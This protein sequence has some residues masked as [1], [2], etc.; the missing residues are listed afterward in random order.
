MNIPN[1][2]TSGTVSISSI[3]MP[4]GIISDVNLTLY[5]EHSCSKDLTANLRSPTGTVVA[6]FDL[7][8]MPLCSSDLQDT[9]FD[10]EAGIG[11]LSGTTPFTG[12]HRPIGDLS[13]FDGE[14][15]A[16]EWVLTIIDDTIG[17]SGVLKA[18]TMEF[19]F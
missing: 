17:D 7:T 8:G 13:D 15:A 5:L 12:P 11:I 10:D 3:A 19:T 18:W 9:I 16:G 1:N 2:G 6:L 14:D 4:Q